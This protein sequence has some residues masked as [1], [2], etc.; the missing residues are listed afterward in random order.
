[1]R[2]G[3]A[4]ASVGERLP[5]AAFNPGGIWQQQ[6]PGPDRDR[7]RRGAIRPSP[8]SAGSRPSLRS[9]GR[10]ALRSTGGWQG[11][12]HP[13]EKILAT[14]FQNRKPRRSASDD[15]ARSAF[16]EYIGS[17]GIGMRAELACRGGKGRTSTAPACI[18]NQAGCPP[19][20]PPSG[21]ESTTWPELWRRRGSDATSAGSAGR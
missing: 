11:N 2:V 16:T 9:G 18:A 12:S 8:Q 10:P 6:R 13:P 7:V 17:R 15:D 21:C 1:M 19:R 20:T 3:P 4:G 14:S 5:A